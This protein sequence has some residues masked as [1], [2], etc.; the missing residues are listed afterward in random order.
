MSVIAANL[1][2]PSLRRTTVAAGAGAAV[3]VTAVAATVHAA[4]VPLAV[5]GEQIPFAG[6]AQ[7]TLLGAIIGGV[8]LAGL[9][10]RST[11]PHRRFLEA[12]TVLTGLSCLPSVALPPDAPTKLA[13][14]V[15][16]VLAAAIVVPALARHANA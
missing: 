8:L 13:L 3:I 6:F 9:N 12:T 15:L 1:T 11:A 16:H 5:G 2:R 7:M 14:V 4:G 10:R